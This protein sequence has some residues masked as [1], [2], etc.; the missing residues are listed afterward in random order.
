VCGDAPEDWVI[1]VVQPGDSL[2]AIAQAVGSTVPELLRAN[3]IPDA[4]SLTS[5]TE[6]YVPVLPEN[7]VVTGVPPAGAIAQQACFDP[8]IAQISSPVAG[9]SVSGEFAVVGTAR[10]RSGFRYYTL[11]VRAA[12]EG[13]PY[14]VVLQAQTRVINGVLGRIDTSAFD[15]GLYWI[16]L[17][18][19]D[20]NG[21]I[22]FGAVCTVP[23]YFEN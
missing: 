5:G 18:V 4:D 9:Q 16:R 2:F 19:F 1:Y 10:L 21:S 11:E 8:D 23:I 12:V 6:L 15:D 7:E 17:T 20:V 14:N 3:C 13:S 22:P